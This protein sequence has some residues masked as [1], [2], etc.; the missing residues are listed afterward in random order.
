MPISVICSGCHA[1]FKV[2][3]QFAGK[4]GPCPKCKHSIKIPDKS[5]EVKVHAPETFGPKGKSGQAVLKPVFREDAKLSTVSII[6]A[7]GA[8]V[9]VLIVAIVV[10]TGLEEGDTE[11]PWFFWFLSG[12]ALLLAPPLAYAGYFSLRDPDFEP[13]Q[14]QSLWARIGVCSLGYAAMWGGFFFIK[15]YLFDG[16]PLQ[17]FQLMFVAPPFVLIGGAIGLA[18][19]DFDYFVG[20]MHFGLYLLVTVLLRVLLLGPVF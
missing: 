9:L 6:A 5:E 13:H 8:A 15:S 10:R 4:T 17:I 3:D 19:F 12:G 20:L 7:V 11:K 1:R 18:C 16:D 14:G 2:S